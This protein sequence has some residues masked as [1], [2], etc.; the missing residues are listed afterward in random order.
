MLAGELA[1]ALAGAWLSAATLVLPRGF[2][3]L[4]TP[5]AFL[6]LQGLLVAGSF[7]IGW[8]MTPRPASRLNAMQALRVCF[9]EAPAFGLAKLAMSI[10]PWRTIAERSPAIVTRSVRPVLLVH[11]VLCNRA[12]WGPLQRRLRAAGFAPIRAVNLEPPAAEIDAVA[13]QLQSELAALRRESQGRRVAVVAHSMGGLVARAA[14][15]RGASDSISQLI[16]LGTPHHGS[17][18][19]RF[20]PG[21]AGEQFQPRS[22]WL[23]ALNAQES[24]SAVPVTSIYSEHDN[25]IAPAQSA[26]LEGA[27]SLALRS[28]GHFAMLRSPVALECVLAKLRST[29]AAKD[30]AP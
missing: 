23:Q 9:S 12:V 13:V 1:V 25:L 3:I 11:G 28:L 7:V 16:T 21:P 26:I 17:V 6:V 18:L 29:A 14:M 30:D 27:E 10:E 4:L 24:L 2:I 8:L 5:L 15:R 19:A 20:V 22:P